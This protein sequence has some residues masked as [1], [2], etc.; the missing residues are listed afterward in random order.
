[1]TTPELSS[2]RFA[3][4]GGLL[5]DGTGRDPLPDSVVLV[6][7]GRIS[8]VDCQDRVQID[9]DWSILN[10]SGKT[11]M[12]GMIDCHVHLICSSMSLERSLFT[13]RTVTTFEAARNMENTLAAGFT[14]VRDA[15]GLDAGY[16]V[17]AERGLI[18]G[19]RLV[20]AGRV[21]SL[22]GHFDYF[23]PNGTEFDFGAEYTPVAGIP[24]VRREV[25]KRIREGYD[26]IKICS[27][28]GITSPSDSPDHTLWTREELQAIVSEAAARGKRVM[29]HA[30]GTQGIKDAIHAGV[31]SVEHG[32]LLDDEA[33]DLFL[34]HGTYLV[35]TLTAVSTIVERGKE[36][37]LGPIAMEKARAYQDLSFE[38]LSRA[39][40]AGIKIATGSDA[41]DVQGHG[42]NALELEL[43]VELGMTPMEAIVSATRTAAEVCQV[44][45]QVG[46]LEPTKQADLLV[47]NGNPLQDI[48]LL[49]DRNRLNMVFKNGQQIPSR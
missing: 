7:K 11:V 43:L 46:T 4:V 48:T 14:T 45:E 25:R 44:E 40:Q 20:V 41:M 18:Q 3:L 29:V 1:M 39:L 24:D 31:W 13:R 38:N 8:A 47:V 28:G 35:P 37:G 33:I 27:T 30:V 17:A 32:R 36:I 2:D 9:P 23:M 26:C 6:E 5:V 21:V 49:Q 16:R 19:P 15:G 34:E 10:V 22:G 12:P 42:R